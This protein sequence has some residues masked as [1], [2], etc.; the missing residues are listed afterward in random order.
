MTVADDTMR[1]G[2]SSIIWMLEGNAWV[3]GIDAV[4]WR[5]TAR[6][7]GVVVPRDS[8]RS[9]NNRDVVGM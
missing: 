7:C 8:S 6:S 4:M 3:V 5:L 1:C 9:C 2:Q